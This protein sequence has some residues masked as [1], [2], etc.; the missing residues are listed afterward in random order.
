VLLGGK[1][2]LMVMVGGTCVEYHVCVV[3]VVC[4]EGARLTMVPMGMPICR[5][6]T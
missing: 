3:A 6:R 5:S 4:H 2:P 1:L